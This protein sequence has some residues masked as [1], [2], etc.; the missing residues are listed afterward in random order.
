MPKTN[1]EYYEELIKNLPASYKKWFDEEERYLKKYIKKGSKVL[2]VACGDGREINYIIDMA[3]EIVGI[4]HDPI[5][6]KH[7]KINFKNKTNAKIMLAEATELSFEDNSF[8]YVTCMG[9]FTNFGENK[10]PALKEMKRVLRDNGKII[11]SAFSENAMPERMK[12]YKKFGKAYG[13]KIKE[14]KKDGTVIFDESLGDN[15]SEQFSEKQLRGFFDEVRLKVEEIK[16]VGIGY[17]CRLSK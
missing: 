6:V 16:K 10:I 7:A 12:I 13:K 8:D 3:G 11:L 1:I 17:I 2:C 15:I 14:I 4:D 5:A 9:S